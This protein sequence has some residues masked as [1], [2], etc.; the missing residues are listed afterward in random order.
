MVDRALRSARRQRLERACMMKRRSKPPNSI[1][2]SSRLAVT[3]ILSHLDIDFDFPKSYAVY[4]TFFLPGNYVVN[5]LPK[6]TRMIMPDTSISLTRAMQVDG[7]TIS[8]RF[9]LDIKVPG[10]RHSL[11]RSFLFWSMCFFYCPAGQIFLSLHRQAHETYQKIEQ[12]KEIFSPVH[13][14]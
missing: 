9:M 13:L 11:T 2:K 12:T 7:N 10:L 5:A 3:H 6:N 8:F 14:K 1:A 4:G